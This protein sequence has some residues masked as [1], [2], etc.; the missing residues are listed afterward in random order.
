MTKPRPIRPAPPLIEAFARQMDRVF[1]RAEHAEAFRDYLT[2]LDLPPHVPKHP[3][4]IAGALPAARFESLR[5]LLTRSAVSFD[6]LNATRVQLLLPWLHADGVLVVGNLYDAPRGRPA[7]DGELGPEH[8]IGMVSCW[9]DDAFSVPLD[10][11]LFDDPSRA[12][13]ADLAVE[14][15]RRAEAQ[16]VPFH[17]MVRAGDDIATGRMLAM[18][19]EADRTAY[20]LGLTHAELLAADAAEQRLVDRL[21]E[22]AHQHPRGGWRNV[23]YARAR[24]LTRWFVRDLSALAPALGTPQLLVATSDPR[25][26]PPD[27]T[28]WLRSNLPP[29][30]PARRRTRSA[31]RPLEE[32]VDPHLAHF[33]Q[34]DVVDRFVAEAT[35]RWGWTDYGGRDQASRHRHWLLICCLY[36]AHLLARLSAP[37][38]DDPA[39]RT[40]GEIFV[41]PERIVSMPLVTE[42]DLVERLHRR[43]GI[44]LKLAGSYAKRLTGSRAVHVV[45]TRWFE[46]PRRVPDM[47]VRGYRLHELVRDHGLTPLHALLLLAG[48]DPDQALAAQRRWIETLPPT[49]PDARWRLYEAGDL[50]LVPLQTQHSADGSTLEVEVNPALVLHDPTAATLADLLTSARHGRLLHEVDRLNDRFLR[51]LGRPAS[52]TDEDD[53]VEPVLYLADDWRATVPVTHGYHRWTLHWY[54]L[55]NQPFVDILLEERGIQ[56]PWHQNPEPAARSVAH[57][58]LH[59]PATAAIVADWILNGAQ[60]LRKIGVHVL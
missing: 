46:E 51:Q 39:S 2:G 32:Q 49:A 21:V 19:L 16:A 59:A 7:A 3:Q 4:G 9:A 20:L 10:I 24:G 31:S 43:M 6:T 36:T 35:Q 17:M 18:N 50:T 1:A 25:T 47:S 42:E 23:L 28:L 44:P 40:A 45:A 8:P 57:H 29:V 30:A 55:H 48:P 37:E 13:T 38:P 26:L 54:R 53:R 15:V 33:L 12:A 60:V 41:P 14:L 22:A 5:Q 52:P 11:M 58:L 27:D 34:H 56:R